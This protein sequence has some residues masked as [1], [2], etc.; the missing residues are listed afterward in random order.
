[1]DRDGIQP[2]NIL[3]DDE[4]TAV[5]ALKKKAPLVIGHAQ[6]DLSFDYADSS[7]LT[8]SRYVRTIERL[9]SRICGMVL[10]G[11]PVY[12]SMPQEYLEAFDHKLQQQLVNKPFLSY[13][14]PYGEGSLQ[15]EDRN[16]RWVVLHADLPSNP[17]FLRRIRSEIAEPDDPND[18]PSF[19]DKWRAHTTMLKD[20]ELAMAIDQE[21]YVRVRERLL[22]RGDTVFEVVVHG[23]GL[24]KYLEGKVI[25]ALRG[26]A[27]VR[28]IRDGRC[29]RIGFKKLV[30]T[31]E[32]W[33]ERFPEEAA[34]EEAAKLAA[35]KEV[36][37]AV[38]DSVKKSI[39]HMGGN[40]GTPPKNNVHQLPVPAVSVEEK[41]DEFE[42]WKSMGKGFF[43]GLEREQAAIKKGLAEVED[44]LRALD[45]Q[46]KK[47]IEE[48]ET[49]IREA[50]RRHV[51]ARAAVAGRVDAGRRKLRAVEKQYNLLKPL[52]SPEG[53]PD[54]R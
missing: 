23:E 48:L 31:R 52:M 25:D 11:V 43:E 7:D 9:A 51:E 14:Q 33:A 35:A 13:Y 39:H 53:E 20:K 6:F 8:L 16:V 5:M 12:H 46:A 41:E 10:L 1:M 21:K 4:I 17:M 19:Y 27:D 24:T 38:G 42:T 45:D 37:I 54:A 50:K 44:M 2:M 26:A 34:K 36:P 49:E 28:F 47:E 40:Q 18:T 22:Q 15:Q 32:L 3:T 30:V 29:V